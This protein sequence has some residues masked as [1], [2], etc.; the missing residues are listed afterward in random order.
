MRLRLTA[1][2]ILLVL[3]VVL[4]PV[5]LLPVSAQMQLA[6]WLGPAAYRAP[7]ATQAVPMGTPE[8][9]CPEDLRGWR[10]A[11]QSG[12][13][14]VD[15]LASPVCSPDNPHLVIAAVKGTNRVSH[16]TLM[17]SGLTPDAVEKGADLDG[18]GD[19]DEITI[20][21]EVAELNGASP[22]T[23]DLMTTYD[24]AP[25]IQPGLWV[26]VPK[27]FGMATKNF[28]SNVAR[29]MLR[30]PSPAIR[31]EQGD[32]VRIVLE[33]TH[34]MPHTIHLHG[35]DHP[36]VDSNGEGNDGVPQV[37]EV[38]VM[39]GQARTY[40]FAARQP[41]TMF[42]HC[43]VQPDVHVLMGLQGMIVIEE[44][45]PDNHVQT[46]NIGAGQVR[47]PSRAVRETWDQE[48]D[49]HYQDI[50]RE[51]NNL[52]Q[53]SNSPRQTIRELHRDYDITDATTDYYLLNGRSFPFTFRESIVTTGADEKIR[54]RVL[55][56]GRESIALH[57]HGHKV[58]VTHRD[59]V[60]AA[61]EIRDVVALAPAQRLDLTLDTHNDG[62]HSYGP[63]IWYFHDHHER[64][65]TTDGISPGG[66]ISAIVY[67]E[68]Q[69]ENGWPKTQGVAWDAYFTPAYYQRR[70]PVWQSYDPFGFF[71]DP[72]ASAGQAVRTL[73]FG[74]VLGLMIMLLAGFRRYSAT[75]AKL[76]K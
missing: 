22:D 36:F 6:A 68:Y 5:A 46:L 55:N 4:F 30:A 44:N 7:A 26:F 42:Y 54:L 43:H 2:A 67:K 47:A 1:L 33:N 31:V 40:E 66:N 58:T 25:G 60:L 45:R 69:G 18:D 10:D 19:P 35:V 71:G 9:A 24:I 27:T 49:L 53:R 48:Y 21:L 23:P 12:V 11:V 3:A 73:L 61:P 34:Y 51:M 62:L 8:V 57:T 56:G 14:G 32:K 15:V 50:D 74:L 59:G 65:V 16:D 75:S 52:I 72:Q 64:A 63:G 13:E 76:V 29:D 38:P 70:I 17:K 41:G 28:E 39:P 20:R 37:S